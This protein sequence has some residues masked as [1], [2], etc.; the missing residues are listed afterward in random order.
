[1][2][3]RSISWKPTSGAPPPDAADFYGQL[4]VQFGGGLDNDLICNNACPERRRYGGDRADNYDAASL[5]NV[6]KD[7][8]DRKRSAPSNQAPPKHILESHLR[9]FHTDQPNETLLSRW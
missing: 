4:G 6:N 3:V 5:A 8:I 7:R 1:M 2:L 9:R